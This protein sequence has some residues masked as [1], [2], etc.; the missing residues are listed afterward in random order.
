MTLLH[1]PAPHPGPGPQLPRAWMYSRRFCLVVAGE[2]LELGPR[3]F[4]RLCEWVWP[5][6]ASSALWLPTKVTQTTCLC[7]SLLTSLPSASAN[8]LLTGHLGTRQEAGLQIDTG[9]IPVHV[10]LPPP[11]THSMGPPTHR[12]H[13]RH[14]GHAP[15]PGL[16]TLTERRGGPGEGLE[17]G[18]L[19][20]L[21]AET[22]SSVHEARR[23]RKGFPAQLLKPGGW[24]EGTSSGFFQHKRERNSPTLLLM[25]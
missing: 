24:S 4:L 15:A 5:C 13:I 3:H 16:S 17:K 21:H 6:T 19:A 20:H 23:G 12:G 22:T 9:D 11:H 8:H 1:Q 18:L 7:L 2:Q 25:R 14:G 10:Y